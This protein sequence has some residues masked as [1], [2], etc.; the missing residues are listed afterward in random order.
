M[1]THEERRELYFLRSRRALL[2]M[3][4]HRAELPLLAPIAEMSL[5]E[6]RCAAFVPVGIGDVDLAGEMEGLV[7]AGIVTPTR[8]SMAW[9]LTDIRAA[10]RWLRGH[11]DRPN[12]MGGAEGTLFEALPVGV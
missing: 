3:L 2:R 4:L 9:R 8:S 5:A 6:L 1:T 12:P 11:P 10:I 7:D